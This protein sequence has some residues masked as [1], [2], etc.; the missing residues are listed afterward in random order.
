MEWKD[1][2]CGLLVGRRGT[3]KLELG[4]DGLM[5]AGLVAAAWAVQVRAADQSSRV[6]ARALHSS[7][8]ED[9]GESATAEGVLEAEKLK[10]RAELKM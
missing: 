9:E 5:G 3:A 2:V 8:N 10:D 4:R 1:T 7:K 6:V